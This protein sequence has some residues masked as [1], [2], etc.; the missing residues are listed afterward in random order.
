MQIKGFDISSFQSV[1][2]TAWFND[3]YQDDF[4]ICIV[5]LW[6][7]TPKLHYGVNPYAGEQLRRAD[8]AGI[9]MLG[10]YIVIPPDTDPCTRF[11]VQAART[12]AGSYTDRLSIVA[13]DIEIDHPLHPT[14][15]TIRLLDAIEHVRQEFKYAKIL[16][17]TRRSVWSRIMGRDNPWPGEVPPVGL[18]DA[19]WLMPSGNDPGYVPDVDTNWKPYG[20]WE[21][22]AGLQYAGNVLINGVRCDLNIFETSRIFPEIPQK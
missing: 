14:C 13:L 9:P 7:T 6:G 16:I 8:I 17:Y 3:M 12:I 19:Y 20:G 18:W 5:Q 22:R 10:G 2:A 15:P 11:I 4:R 21:K 1:P